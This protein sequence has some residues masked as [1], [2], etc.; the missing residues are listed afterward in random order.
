MSRWRC[1]GRMLAGLVVVLAVELTADA[2]WAVSVQTLSN[3]VP[4]GGIVIDGNISDW[5]AVTPFLTDAVGDGSSGA[6]RPLDIDI[7]YGAVAH[8]DNYFYVLYRN[9]GPNMVDPFS[10]WVFFDLDQDPATGYSGAPELSSIGMEFNLGGT[11][12]WNNWSAGGSF[13]GGG[14]GKTVAVGAT[15][16]SGPDFLEWSISRTA[17][18]PNGGTFNPTGTSFNVIFGAEDTV[19]DTSPDNGDVNWFTYQVVPEPATSCLAVLALGALTMW[20][21]NERR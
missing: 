4:N 8:D 2:V 3:P 9:A 12:G 18:Q 19:L 7:L 14:A 20:R 17:I 13:L 15:G 16:L 5:A 11:E 1:A 6:A 10:N 21:R